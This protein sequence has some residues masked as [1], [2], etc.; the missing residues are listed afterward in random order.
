MPTGRTILVSLALVGVML[1]MT[2]VS[3]MPMKCAGNDRGA[4]EQNKCCSKHPATP[5]ERDRSEDGGN[6][7]AACCRII[8]TNS[9]DVGVKLAG[10]APPIPAMTIASVVASDLTDPES[11][12]H[13][14]KA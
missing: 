13:P 2:T 1:S 8:S 14:P 4:V 9:V 6:C 12:F 5:G 11:I 3:A 7:L 10:D